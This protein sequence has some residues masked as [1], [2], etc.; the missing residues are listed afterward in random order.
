M[1]S[2]AKAHAN[3]ALCKYWG[4]RDSRLNLPAVGSISMTLQALSTQTAVDF[5]DDLP[6]DRLILN[7]KPASERACRRVSDFLDVLRREAG[8]KLHAQVD[9]RNEFP[10]GAGLASSASSFAALSAA[11][12]HA[13]GLNYPKPRLSQLARRGSGSAA[14]SIFGGFVEMQAGQSPSGEDA[15]AVQ[16]YDEHYWPLEMVILITDPAR[17]KIGSTEGMNL[18]AETS[19]YY[20]A[21]I[22]SSG[23]DLAEVRQALAQ[24]D[25]E[26]LGE[27]TE[28]SCLKMHALA[29]AA[30]P[31][32]LYWNGTTVQLLHEVR[33]L[34][35]AGLLIFFTVDAGPQ[36]KVL[37]LP[38]EGQKVKA[39]LTG[40][41]G[42]H[43][44]L[45]STIG[46][47]VTLVDD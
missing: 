26:K 44:I 20:R 38:G 3:I 42:V 34:R 36:V 10:T 16:L 15:L 19:P 14:R 35:A 30:R 8:V 21:W 5:R 7:G 25:F 17:K 11:A 32:L 40:M 33:R 29:L 4:K 31:G 22:D 47:G 24:K 6:A 27:L 12:A 2:T 1:K 46:P 18:T 43:D 41:P 28:F 23:K 37:C 13:L 39:R 45:V 9:S